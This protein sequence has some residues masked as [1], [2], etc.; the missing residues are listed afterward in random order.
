[1]GS[2]PG[3]AALRSPQAGAVCRDYVTGFHKRKVARRKEALGCEPVHSPGSA[4]YKGF[5]CMPHGFG[6]M[7]L[8]GFIADMVVNLGCRVFRP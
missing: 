5:V 6:L 4:G 1:M 2:L 7:P 8:F 3:S